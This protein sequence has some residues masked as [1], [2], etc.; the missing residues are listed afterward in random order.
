MTRPVQAGEVRLERVPVAVA[1]GL[2]RGDLSRPATW[3]P[4]FPAAGTLSA[5]RMLL[6]TYEALGVDPEGSPW[7]FFCVVVE[8]VVVGDAGFHGPPPQDG[9]AE[10]EIGYQ[11]VPA[12]RGRG[13]ATRAC[14]LLLTHAWAH[15]ADVVRAEVEPDNPYGPASRAVLLANGL[16]PDG[17]LGFVAERPVGPRT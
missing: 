10:V 7:W 6:G 2:V 9:P 5:A 17:D 16:R 4:Q 13:V 3:H 14:A 15:G 11:V 12:L 1:R 8:G